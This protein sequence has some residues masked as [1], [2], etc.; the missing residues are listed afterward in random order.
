[1]V[2]RFSSYRAR[3]RE[4][5]REHP[6]SQPFPEIV[7]GA[8]RDPGVILEHLVESTADREESQRDPSASEPREAMHDRAP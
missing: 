1:M 4:D 5:Q 3:D 8:H 6:E 7:L 2:S